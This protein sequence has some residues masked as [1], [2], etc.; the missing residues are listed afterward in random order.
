MN[1]RRLVGLVAVLVT[2]VVAPHAAAAP[3]PV[4]LS[5]EITLGG[6]NW[7]T[8][9]MPDL[10][11]VRARTLTVMGL[12]G[13]GENY[14]GPT[15]AVDVLSYLARGGFRTGV[16]GTTDFAAPENYD[17]GTEA[18]REM[19]V[20]MNTS[21]T[22]GTGVLE[23]VDTFQ[24]HLGRS[25]A[26]G[27]LHAEG[28]SYRSTDRLA[29]TPQE[30]A[31]IGIDG[32]V[33]AL[34]LGRYTTST[35]NVGTFFR[36]IGGHF[37]V[38]SGVSTAR[39]YAA[40]TLN[41]TDP[42]TSN[43]KDATQSPFVA[44]TYTMTMSTVRVQPISGAVETHRVGILDGI[45]AGW[46]VEG[47]VALYPERY[48]TIRDGS[49]VRLTPKPF[50]DDGPTTDRYDLDSR[51]VDGAFSAR[52]GR[53]YALLRNGSVVAVGIGPGGKGGRMVDQRIARVPGATSLDVA[54]TGDVIVGG[55]TSLRKIGVNGVDGS[56]RTSSAI[57]D[58]AVEPT[59]GI[60]AL[61]G[62]GLVLER[63]DERLKRS[64]V[65][66][67]ARPATGLDLN[68]K[69]VVV[70]ASIVRG[71]DA[72]RRDDHGALVV[73]ADGRLSVRGGQGE[74][75]VKPQTGVGRLVAVHR[76]W[77]LYD[78]KAYP[79]PIDTETRELLEPPPAPPL[80]P[81]TPQ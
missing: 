23:F 73:T 4:E 72:V 7:K 12:P 30:L 52:T 36:R 18:I 70:P 22:G 67:L 55:G 24:Q 66:R 53:P 9:G 45:F 42:W 26:V 34:I 8:T 16:D 54:A 65:K 15:T 47:Y 6:L 32:A 62:K 50:F 3:S 59:G 37:A 71:T 28:G 5:T 69:G 43:V 1:P 10:D 80:P 48:L 21:A 27:T 40:A 60:V 35:D 13:N 2:G 19:G 44:E 31:E 64:V 41:I 77:E 46:H 56:I 11:Q 49:L 78:A 68:A 58:V 63:F 14:C 38:L 39:P 20:E 25:A 81:L 17:A 75:I 79:G 51:V 57:I 76:A 29:P 33:V 74:G 61:T